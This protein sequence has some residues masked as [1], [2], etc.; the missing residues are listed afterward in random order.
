MTHQIK[1]NDYFDAE[2][3][4]FGKY[5][6]IKPALVMAAIATSIVGVIMTAPYIL[7][8]IQSVF[9]FLMFFGLLG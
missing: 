6:W 4:E 7:E 1:D 3:Q 5:S 2:A 9:M 8:T